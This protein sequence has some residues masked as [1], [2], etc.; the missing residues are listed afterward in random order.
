LQQNTAFIF[1]TYL[2]RNME[3][4]G[5]VDDRNENHLSDSASAATSNWAQQLEDAIRNHCHDELQELLNSGVAIHEV[6]LKYKFEE[7]ETNVELDVNPLTLAVALGCDLATETL[8]KY[9]SDVETE[10][11]VIGGSVLHL[12][13]RYGSSAIMTQLLSKDT[14]RDQQDK[15]EHTPLHL[16]TRYDKQEI[17]SCLLEHGADSTLRN[18]DGHAAFQVAAMYGRVEILKTL[19]ERSSDD[20]VN[21]KN[22]GSNA[23]IH[24]ACINHRAEAVEWLLDQGAS[25]NQ[26]GQSGMTPLAVA[27]AENAIDCAKVLLKRGADVHKRNI[28]M[29]TPLLLA[30]LNGRAEICDLLRSHGALISDVD[31]NGNTCFH[32]VILDDAPWTEQRGEIFDLLFGAGL[33]INQPNIFGFPPLILACQ[34]ER[35][36]HLEHLLKL[37]ADVD[38]VSR[39]GGITALMEA[40]CKSSSDLVPKL[41]EKGADTA[42]TNAHGLTSLALAC[43]HGRLENAKLLIEKGSKVSVHDR[44]GNTP[45]RT[46]LIHHAVEIAFEILMADYR[47]RPSAPLKRPKKREHQ[48]HETEECLLQ[49]VAETKSLSVERLQSIM[50]W[51]VSNG[52]LEL[53]RSCVSYNEEVLQW[54]HNGGGWLHAASE[55]GAHEI[56]KFL[57][58]LAPAQPT[59]NKVWTNFKAIIRENHQGESPLSIS[60]RMGLPQMEKLFWSEFERYEEIDK[61]FMHDHAAETDDVLE[62]LARYERPGHEDILRN[63]LKHLAGDDLQLTQDYTTLQWAVRCSRA[64]VVWWLLSK[65]G[66]SSAGVIQEAAKLVAHGSHDNISETKVKDVIREL[67]DH[68]PPH[69]DHIDNPNKEHLSAFPPEALQVAHPTSRCIGTVL[70]VVSHGGMIKV[71]W[72]TASLQDIIYKKGPDALM[73]QARDHPRSLNRESMHQLGLVELKKTLQKAAHLSHKS[74]QAFDFQSPESQDDPHADPTDS[75]SNFPGTAASKKRSDTTHDALQL[76]WVHLPVNEVRVDRNECG[77]G[78]RANGICVSCT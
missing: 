27:C 75:N 72:V 62:A 65:G 74:P 66:Y 31:A 28:H 39:S 71:P 78:T 76:R 36:Q 53:T 12:A 60:I 50:Y 52:A 59:E 29:N 19:F 47:N 68:P 18:D 55:N 43:R 42:R 20:Q 23:P 51:A 56:A 16:A 48:A 38:L 41:L 30:C 34:E 44:D 17:V 13:A 70:D 4:P 2:R 33:D 5:D 37:G 73:R 24:L 7:G 64:A 21:E 22:R 46:A 8:L 14:D 11:P 77:Y 67:L 61:Q 3:T 26:P 69:L 58:E 9:G 1:S 35:P 63:F 15:R 45:L 40:S 49:A 6:V 32:K 54:N 57:L 10:L 25:I